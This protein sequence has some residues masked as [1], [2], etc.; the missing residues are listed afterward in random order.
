MVVLILMLPDLL[1]HLFCCT[2]NDALVVECVHAPQSH[3]KSVNERIKKR[4]NYSWFRFTQVDVIIRTLCLYIFRLCILNMHIISMCTRIHMMTAGDREAIGNVHCPSIA[5]VLKMC[6]FRLQ[7]P[8]Q[9]ASTSIIIGP[10]GQ[11][12]PLPLQFQNK[13]PPHIVQAPPTIDPH[14]TKNIMRTVN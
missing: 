7:R 10:L 8:V 3:A 4:T 6:Q 13:R 11:P 12:P 14:H 2:R 1:I 5:I 9:I